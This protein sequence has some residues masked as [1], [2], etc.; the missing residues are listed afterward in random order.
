M[1]FQRW[2]KGH[3]WF[4]YQP[5]IDIYY[6]NTGGSHPTLEHIYI[7]LM[8]NLQLRWFEG[9]LV[10]LPQNETECPETNGRKEPCFAQTNLFDTFETTRVLSNITYQTV[11]KLKSSSAKSFFTPVI[12]EL[13]RLS[14]DEISWLILARILE[15][16]LLILLFGLCMETNL[17]FQGLRTEKRW[18]QL[19]KTW[20]VGQNR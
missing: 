8:Y 11:N 15:R 5:T 19:R 9:F 2:W 17:K 20:Q 12:I 14:V 18:K 10:W 7:F 3:Q 16:C 1:I 13:S 4:H 6:I